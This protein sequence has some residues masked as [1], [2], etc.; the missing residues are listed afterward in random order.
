MSEAKRFL[1]EPIE[2]SMKIVFA[3]GI[4]GSIGMIA[5]A[6]VLW[7]QTLPAPTTTAA[8]LTRNCESASPTPPIGIPVGTSGFVI[9]RCALTTPAFTVNPDGG[10]VTPSFTLGTGFTTVFAYP[11]VTGPLTNCLSAT[12]EKQLTSGS[13]VTFSVGEVGGWNYCSD[14]ASAPVTFGETV[15]SWSQP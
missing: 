9:W 1:R 2:R 5:V 12:G 7:N 8:V 3:I 14:Y 15:V 10:T 6:A 11:A 13:S 4:V